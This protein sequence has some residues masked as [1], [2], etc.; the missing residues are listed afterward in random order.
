LLQIED[1]SVWDVRSK[2]SVAA[3]KSSICQN[4]KTAINAV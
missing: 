4:I 2:A 3:N 1:L